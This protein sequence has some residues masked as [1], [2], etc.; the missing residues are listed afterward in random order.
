MSIYLR[1]LSKLLER[2]ELPLLKQENYQAQQVLPM[3]LVI[4]YTTG[5]LELKKDNGL[6]CRSL[7]M[8]NMEFQKE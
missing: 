2:G 3:P 7:A 6:Q 4:I 1:V 5:L 8:D